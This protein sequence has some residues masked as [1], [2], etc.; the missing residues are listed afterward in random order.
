MSLIETKLSA[1]F[2]V[3]FQFAKIGPSFR[4][5]HFPAGCRDEIA[6]MRAIPKMSAELDRDDPAKSENKVGSRK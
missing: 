3:N 1:H 6:L 2:F 5:L 4:P